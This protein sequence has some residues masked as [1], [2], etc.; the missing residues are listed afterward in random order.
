MSDAERSE[1]PVLSRPG[2]GER[3]ERENRAV[4]IRVD[5][6]DLS[7]HEIE[8]D[9]TFEVHALVSLH[10]V[11]HE[12]VPDAIPVSQVSPLSTTLL[13]HAGEQSLSV[14]EFAPG[15]QQP[16]LLIAVV[17]GVLLHDA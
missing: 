11:G 12:P 10:V 9:S 16:S 5:L 1:E 7:V 14:P 6:P 13:P 15:G 3:F 17:I 8:F 4:T 2:E